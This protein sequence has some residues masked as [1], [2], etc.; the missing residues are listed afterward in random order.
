MA[1]VTQIT[2]AGEVIALARALLSQ[3]PPPRSA[4]E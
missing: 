3:I 2:K 4:S 1:S